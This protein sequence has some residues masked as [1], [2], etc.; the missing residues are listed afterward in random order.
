MKI[1][2]IVFL[3]IIFYRRWF[4]LVSLKAKK[5][6][7]SVATHINN[8]VCVADFLEDDSHY[9]RMPRMIFDQDEGLSILKH[10]IEPA[11]IDAE[12]DAPAASLSWSPMNEQWLHHARS[13]KKGKVVFCYR[14][15]W[16]PVFKCRQLQA[17]VT[18]GRSIR[19]EPATVN[20]EKWRS[21]AFKGRQAN[22]EA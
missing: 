17:V 9:R 8:C 13:I 2:S 14:N 22:R 15:H 10:W 5:T 11:N 12:V 21:R 6:S 16:I 4:Y 18:L 7:N 19:R 1:Q 3:W 20:H